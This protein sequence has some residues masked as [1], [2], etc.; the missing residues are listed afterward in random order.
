MSILTAPGRW[1]VR[2]RP[3]IPPKKREDYTI[4]KATWEEMS[5]EGRQAVLRTTAESNVRV[6]TIGFWML[7]SVAV[8]IVA[9][10]V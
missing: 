1:I 4:D 3:P 2:V 10:S 6:N 9:M 5:P 7:V 8:A